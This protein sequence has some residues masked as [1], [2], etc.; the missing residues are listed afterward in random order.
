[1]KLGLEGKVAIVTGG[2]RGIGFACASELLNEG[3]KVVIVSQDP[4]RNRAAAEV[5]AKTAGDRVLGIAA[6]L[7]EP[8]AV[9]S[10][11]AATRD[12]FGG[13]EVLVNC[14]APVGGAAV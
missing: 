12:R 8:K 7:R 5:L 6:D 9:D 2:S 3:G 1:M 11:I 4:Q 10:A 14:A 13:G